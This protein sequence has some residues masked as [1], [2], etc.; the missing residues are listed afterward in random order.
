MLEWLTFI[1]A[2]AAAVFQGRRAVQG[3]LYDRAARREARRSDLS[4]W[5]STGVD[6]WMVH[7]AG[8][9]S[10]PDAT[11]TLVTRSPDQAGRLRRYLEEH[12]S[13]SRNPSPAELEALD[14]ASRNGGEVVP[15]ARRA[16]R[17]RLFRA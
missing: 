15:M 5:S 10:D 11:V 4:G 12:E 2:T 9:D 3:W 7:L 1:S 6:A 17:L 8:P 13:L 16:W 14:A